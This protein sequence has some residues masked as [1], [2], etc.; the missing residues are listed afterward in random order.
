MEFMAISKFRDTP[1]VPLTA[2]MN[3]LEVKNSRPTKEWVPIEAERKAF[4]K[5]FC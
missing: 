4:T 2:Q 5:I 1:A 3:V